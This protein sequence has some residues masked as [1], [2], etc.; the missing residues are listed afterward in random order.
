MDLFYPF[1]PNSIFDF[2]SK[3]C[4]RSSIEDFKAWSLSLSTLEVMEL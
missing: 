3:S 4:I 2:T 1:Q